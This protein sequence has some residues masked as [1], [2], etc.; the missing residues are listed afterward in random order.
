MKKGIIFL[1][2]VFSVFMLWYL[3]LKP[4]DYIINFTSRS[5]PGTINQS[6]K[7]W[8]M[9]LKNSSV[10]TQ[11]N[12]QNIFQTL[13]FSDSIYEYNWKI[14][15]MND[16]LSKVSVG[17]TDDKLTNSIAN[18]L[19]AP[20]FKTDFTRRSENTVLEFMKV[21]KD[22]IDGFK[23]TIIGE[24]ETPYKFFAYVALTKKQFHKA[25]GMMENS[26]YISDILLKNNIEL[27]GFPIVEVL[28][29][30]KDTDSLTY[31]FGFPIKKIA[32]LANLGKVKFKSLQPQRGLKAIYNGNY[33]TSDRAWYTLLNY[34]EKQKINLK[35]TP[36]EIFH[37]NPHMGGDSMKWVTEVY[38][39]I[40]D[41]AP[42]N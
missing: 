27:D 17:I 30:N 18:R 40:N 42:K 41:T 7:L 37:N 5:L 14:T 33:I 1:L 29:W 3:F 10:P 12:S 21:L 25:Q 20:F 36:I 31:N 22:H 38:F 34:A 8:G 9:G 26:N 35:E 39:P 6:I 23:V 13:T 28:E 11:K 32:S 4:S 15:P 24:E 2:V 16:S 19:K